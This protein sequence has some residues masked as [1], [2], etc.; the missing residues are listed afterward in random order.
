MKKLFAVLTLLAVSSL[1]HA[2]D[3]KPAA[4]ADA[5]A[6]PD[7]KAELELCCDDDAKPADPKTAKVAEQ[8]SDA[9]KKAAP[10]PATK[11]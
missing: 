9:E 10:K 2:A 11:K 5:K 3:P 4:P 7:R 6:K 1:I 8:K